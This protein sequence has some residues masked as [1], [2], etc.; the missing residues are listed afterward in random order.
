MSDVDVIE[1]VMRQLGETDQ[2]VDEEIA[3]EISR[4][5]REKYKNKKPIIIEFD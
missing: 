4:K 3:K 1:E 2:V 5:L